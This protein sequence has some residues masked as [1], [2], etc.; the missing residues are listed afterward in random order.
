MKLQQRR[1]AKWNPSRRGSGLAGTVGT[2]EAARNKVD[3]AAAEAESKM[4]EMLSPAISQRAM[5]QWKQFY[6][7]KKGEREWMR[8]PESIQ[9]GR[10]ER[11]AGGEDAGTKLSTESKTNS[12]LYQ[13]NQGRMFLR[14]LKEKIPSRLLEYL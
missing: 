6:P 9:N 2:A 11:N 8:T 4:R 5:K 1:Q 10:D 12:T 3:S 7:N 13:L 14:I